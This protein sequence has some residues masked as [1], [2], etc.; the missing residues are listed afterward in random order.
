M[1]QLIQNAKQRY[2]DANGNALAGGSVAY[3]VPG[4]LTA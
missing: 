2:V 4:T 3:Y 1:S